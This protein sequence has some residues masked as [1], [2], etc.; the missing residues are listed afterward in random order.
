MN[1]RLVHQSF[2]VNVYVYISAKRLA[3]RHQD[4]SVYQTGIVRERSG[5]VTPENY[6]YSTNYAPLVILNKKKTMVTLLVHTVIA[7]QIR[8]IPVPHG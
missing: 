5:V 4:L 7:L 6:A 1:S 3:Q 8:S 2:R